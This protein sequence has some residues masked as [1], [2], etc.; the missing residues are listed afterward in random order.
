MEVTRPGEDTGGHGRVHRGAM[1]EGRVHRGDMAVE[2]AS[3]RTTTARVAII[4][5]LLLVGLLK[6][7]PVGLLLKGGP[8]GTGTI[9][10]C[11]EP[12]RVLA[13]YTACERRAA[14]ACCSCGTHAGGLH[15]LGS[16]GP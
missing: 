5:R 7:E 14:C 8:E 2:G 4:L 16:G 1:A 3:T 10:R 9:G 15:L 13:M 11:E 6:E 12:H